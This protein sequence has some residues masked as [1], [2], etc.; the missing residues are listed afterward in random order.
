[1]PIPQRPQKTSNGRDGSSGAIAEGAVY[2]EALDGKAA[3][4]G[5]LNRAAGLGKAR[6][7]RYNAMS[8]PDIVMLSADMKV[9]GD[10]SAI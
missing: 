4:R 9:V 7:S 8:I 5:M 6:L 10:R 3:D 2:G 1:M